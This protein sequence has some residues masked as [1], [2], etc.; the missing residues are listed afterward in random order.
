MVGSCG[1][2]RLSVHEELSFFSRG[3]NPV[4]RR[5]GAE[6]QLCFQWEVTYMQIILQMMTA[7]LCDKD[8]RAF[9]RDPSTWWQCYRLR[10][11]EFW[12]FE[13]PWGKELVDTGEVPTWILYYPSNHALVT[14]N[15]KVL[16]RWP[17][18][19]FSE[20]HW[21]CLVSVLSGPVLSLG[22]HTQAWVMTNGWLFV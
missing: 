5:A 22:M 2:R 13:S 19:C 6:V 18:A 14:Q 21:F 4:A 20:L 12:G 15:P 10:Q 7:S 17:P 1:G 9:P 3:R 8:L 11:V 16:L